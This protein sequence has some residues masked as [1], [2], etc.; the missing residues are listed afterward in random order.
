MARLLDDLLTLST[1]EAGALRLHLEPAEPAEL[2]RDAVAAF[3]PRA[4]GAGVR[5]EVQVATGL[6]RLEVDPVRIGEVLSNLLANALRHGTP[7]APVRVEA[8]TNVTK[9]ELSVAN[10]GHPIPTETQKRLFQP[11]ARA[12]A[13]PGQQGL[14]LGLYIAH[15]IARAHGGTLAVSSTPEETRFTFRMPLG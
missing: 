8:H 5:L 6:P 9:L 7:D 1:A 14:G 13:R 11:F 2:V 15:E 10:R 12:S 3:R 4:D